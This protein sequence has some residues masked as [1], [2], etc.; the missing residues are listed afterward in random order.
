MSDADK[1]VLGDVA[2]KHGLSSEAMK[3]LLGEY[4]TR[5]KSTQEAAV[6][7]FVETNEKW[8]AE[9]KADK[10]IGGDK[11]P[12]VLQTIGKVLDNPKL[13]DPGFK[14]ALNYTGAGNN[15]AI[16]KTFYKMALALTEGGH[17]GG[18]PPAEAGQKPTGAAALYPNLPKG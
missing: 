6:K 13:T 9:I 16:V 8:Q 4:A 5:M 7:A 3:D 17:V 2:K 1:T 11:L 15:P 10:E 14:E 12:A 18:T